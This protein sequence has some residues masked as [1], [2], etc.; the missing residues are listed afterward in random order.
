VVLLKS[1]AEMRAM[2]MTKIA[3]TA[4]SLSMVA[5]PIVGSAGVIG[6]IFLE[7]YE[8]AA[9]YDKEDARLLKTIGARLGVAPA[10]ARLF[11]HTQRLLKET[12]QRAAELAVI[13][14]IQQGIAA[15]LDFQGIIDLV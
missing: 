2:G 6:A 8:R 1:R 12:E 15:S 10:N 5:A 3:G 11:E 4:Q 13:N 14:S 9:A 7:N